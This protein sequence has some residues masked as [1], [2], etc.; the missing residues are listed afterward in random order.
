[1]K[2][3]AVLL[4]L[5]YVVALFASINRYGSPTWVLLVWA[6]IVLFIAALLRV[7]AVVNAPMRR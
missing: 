2:T 5:T 3:A 1:M 4:A 6:G 7:H